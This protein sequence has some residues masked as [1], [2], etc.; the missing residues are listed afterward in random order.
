MKR[1]LLPNPALKADVPR[2]F[3]RM[4]SRSGGTPAT[5]IR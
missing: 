5:L 4:A 3:V 2:T 1:L